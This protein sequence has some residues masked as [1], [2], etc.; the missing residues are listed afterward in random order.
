MRQRKRPLDISE[1]WENYLVSSDMSMGNTNNDP[2]AVYSSWPLT[3]SPVRNPKPSEFD[4]PV[5]RSGTFITAVGL[6]IELLDP[7][8]FSREEPLSDT[9]DGYLKEILSSPCSKQD[10]RLNG[11]RTTH[12]VMT[13]GSSPPEPGPTKKRRITP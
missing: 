12:M 6:G 11:K 10:E 3:V 1:G 8:M 9:A 5:L 7:F 13:M 2:F 4:S